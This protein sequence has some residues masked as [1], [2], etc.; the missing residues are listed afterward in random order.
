LILTLSR[1][2]WV[3]LAVSFVFLTLT[4]VKR[5]WLSARVPIACAVVLT[6]VVLP[7]GGT[8]AT[9]ITGSDRASAASRVPLFHLA[10]AV[11]K[12]H[13]VIGVGANNLGIVFPRYAGPQ[14]SQDWIYT[15]HNKYLLVW[16]EAGTGA[17]AAFLWF[18][19]STLR[20]G[21]S[22]W[23]SQDPLFSLFGLG[24]IA[25]LIGQMV[26]MTVEIFQSRPD[27]Q[28]LSLVAALLVALQKVVR[29]DHAD[30]RT[31]STEAALTARGSSR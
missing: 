21:W 25:G 29:S 6:L 5:G 14:Y 4:G 16:A 15:V 7:F 30:G 18:L 10:G 28:G 12:D 11:I 24:L 3:A 22:V 2:A 1:G 23:R 19:F 8:L 26:D 27:V 17:L 20:R 9:R 31:G 13:P